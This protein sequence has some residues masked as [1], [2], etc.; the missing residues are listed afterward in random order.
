MDKNDYNK[1]NQNQQPKVG[2]MNNLG[3]SQPPAY[4]AP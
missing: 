4:T 2:L 1:L 3:I